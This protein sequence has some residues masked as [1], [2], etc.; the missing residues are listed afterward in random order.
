MANPIVQAVID[1]ATQDVT[2]MKS[3]ETTINGIAAVVQAAVDAALL[4]GATA[5]QLAPVSDVVTALTSERTA[6]ATAIANSPGGPVPT[7]VVGDNLPP[8]QG[9]AMPQAGVTVNDPATARSARP[10]KA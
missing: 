10:H 5:A 6:L 2:V 7:P 1:E 9:Q 8:A 3:A 4:N